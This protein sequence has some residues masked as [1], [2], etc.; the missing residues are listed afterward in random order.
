MTKMGF[1]AERVGVLALVLSLSVCLA[2]AGTAVA[3]KKKKSPT[4]DVTVQLN[5]QVPPSTPGPPGQNGNLASSLTL[6][7]KFK[8]QLIK[9]V[10]ARIVAGGNDVGG[11]AVRLSAPNGN[12]ICLFGCASGLFGTTIGPLTLDVETPIILSGA[13]PQFFKDPTQ[14]SAP[15]AGTAHP[16]GTLS[17]LDGGPSRGTWTLHAANADPSNPV[18]ISQWGIHVTTHRPYLTK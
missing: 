18:M 4:A 16:E 6:G 13:N 15:Y 10:N 11:L 9:D 5:G 12:T 1:R 14:L 2:S 3:K 17:D 8:G 7:K